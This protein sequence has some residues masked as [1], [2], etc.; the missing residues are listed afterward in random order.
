MLASLS[1]R[2]F[3]AAALLVVLAI[4][5]TAAFVSARVTSEAEAELQRGLVESGFVVGRQSEALVDTFTLLARLTADLPK[6]KAAVATGDPAT[7]EPLAADYQRML[8]RSSLVVVTDQDGRVLASTGPAAER[9]VPVETLPA[10]PVTP[11]GAPLSSFRAH[12]GGILQVLSVPITVGG[13]PARLAGTLSVGFLL[14]DALASD[15]RQLTGSEI[16]FGLDGKIRAATLPE[17]AW[18]A[19]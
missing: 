6:L 12:A 17:A 15:F 1:N 8:A 18:P 16:A 4:G 3:M 5:F 7:V 19:I 2:I 10:V 13:E 14:D 9:S 11:G